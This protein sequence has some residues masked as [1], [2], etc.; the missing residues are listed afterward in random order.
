MPDTQHNKKE[1]DKNK[2]PVGPQRYT[3]VNP[4]HKK[5]DHLKHSNNPNP[6][7][8]GDPTRPPI[9]S[10]GHAERGNLINK[11]EVP[12]PGKYQITGDFEK[13]MEKP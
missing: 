6:T 13:A 3:P 12:G 10:I 8:R 5:S 1:E 2:E 9:T 4:N 7:L 11:V